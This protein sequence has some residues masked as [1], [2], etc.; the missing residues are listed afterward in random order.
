MSDYEYTTD[1]YSVVA[2]YSSGDEV[3]VTASAKIEGNNVKVSSKGGLTFSSGNTNGHIYTVKV[4]YGGKSVSEDVYA[5]KVGDI[6][7]IKIKQSKLFVD[8]SLAHSGI[9]GITYMDDYGSMETDNNLSKTGKVKIYDK[10]GNEQV[11]GTLSSIRAIKDGG[12][13][14]S[15]SVYE[16]SEA[17]FIDITVLPTT[18]IKYIRISL[19]D[20]TKPKA[21][22]SINLGNFVATYMKSY[23]ARVGNASTYTESDAKSIVY[24]TDSAGKVA[25]GYSI[26][27]TVS[28]GNSENVQSGEFKTGDVVHITVKTTSGDI[29]SNQ[30]DYTIQ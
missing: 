17:Y 6:K 15:Y 21:G 23:W 7:E 28:S 30:L 12:A 18:D 9:A 2:V 26:S 3:N 8:A 27:V 16:N 1:D 22:E 29:A 14:I 20:L 13:K 4:S 10:N 19:S 11:S 24:V 5:Y 25:D